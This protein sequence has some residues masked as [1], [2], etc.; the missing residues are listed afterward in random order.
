MPFIWVVQSKKWNL[1]WYLYNFYE[2]LL[3]FFFTLFLVN[4]Q[5]AMRDASEIFT[6]PSI[7]PGRKKNDDWNE[8]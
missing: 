7:D 5:H 8:L 1:W 6:A 2:V 4:P 3:S